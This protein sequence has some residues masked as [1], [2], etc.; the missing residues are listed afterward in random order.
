M[1]DGPLVL[2]YNFCHTPCCWLS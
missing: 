2:R 1:D